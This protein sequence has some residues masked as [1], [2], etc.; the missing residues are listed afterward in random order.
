MDDVD[1]S[2][3]T[4]ETLCFLQGLISHIYISIGYVWLGGWGL[5]DAA[6]LSIADRVI[7]RRVLLEF[8]QPCIL[9][10][11]VYIS[12]Q[13][14]CDGSCTRKDALKVTIGHCVIIEAY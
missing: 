3:V 2:P 4:S 5:L 1:A 10:C 11:T 13:L 7:I 6:S 9:G 12:L 8:R 14:L